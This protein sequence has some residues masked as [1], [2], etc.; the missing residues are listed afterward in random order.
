MVVSQSALEQWLATNCM[1]KSVKQLNGVSTAGASPLP[2]ACEELSRSDSTLSENPT[3]L[4]AQVSES[5]NSILCM[6]NLLDHNKAGLMKRIS[7]VCVTPILL[8]TLR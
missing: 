5:K 4:Q 7:R 1:K 8:R 6:H 3:P 2:T